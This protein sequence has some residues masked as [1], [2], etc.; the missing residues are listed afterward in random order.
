MYDQSHNL[1]TYLCIPFTPMN[2]AETLSEVVRSRCTDRPI[3]VT[4]HA[5][6]LLA[7]LIDQYCF[8]GCRLWSSSVTLPAAAGR[9][10]GRNCT[11]GQS[12]YVPFRAAL[13][14]V[15]ARVLCQMRAPYRPITR[16]PLP[17][18]AG[19]KTAVQHP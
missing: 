6:L 15:R 5:L 17:P 14:L 16:L 9:V 19:P 11:A 2:D 1:H 8:A 7:R 4:N 13:R 3:L 12:C 10:G 18:I